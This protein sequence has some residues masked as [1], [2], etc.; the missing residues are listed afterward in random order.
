ERRADHRAALALVLR[1]LAVEG[2]RQVAAAGVERHRGGRREGDALVGRAE[3]H[4][5]GAPGLLRAQQQLGIEPGQP[6]ERGAVVEE[7]GIEEVGRQ[8]P[9]LGPELAEPEHPGIERE[10]D[11]LLRWSQRD[12]RVAWS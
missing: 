6:A 9:R 4:V 12:P 8:P 2:E 10:A 7:P 11:E 3:Q 5:E 1:L